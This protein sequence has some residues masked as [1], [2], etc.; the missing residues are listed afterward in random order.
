[1]STHTVSTTSGATVSA[2]AIARAEEQVR[3]LSDRLVAA[4]ALLRELRG[5]TA[6]AKSSPRECECGCGGLTSGGM[7]QPGHDAKMRSAL[8][9]QIRDGATPEAEVAALAKLR[10]YPGLAHG[11]GD[12]DLGKVRKER[13]AKESRAAERKSDSDRAKAQAESDKA[14]RLAMQAKSRAEQN[15]IAEH[16]AVTKD[17]AI[18]EAKKAGPIT[19]PAQKSK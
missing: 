14:N 15:A 19:V 3:V 16:I 17:A 5:A 2:E 9:A 11:I 12:W 7:F 10:E 6:K 18:A 8:L 4:K 1:M 13:V